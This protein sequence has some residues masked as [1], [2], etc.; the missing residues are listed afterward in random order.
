MAH[1]LWIW[2]CTVYLDVLEFRDSGEGGDVLLWAV[3]L[4]EMG[5]TFPAQLFFREEIKYFFGE[6]G[7]QGNIF[8]VIENLLGTRSGSGLFHYR[9]W[10]VFLPDM[11]QL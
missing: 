7:V 5:N 2:Q 10:H 6:L 1:Y 11:A 8:L 9:E 3:L 4:L